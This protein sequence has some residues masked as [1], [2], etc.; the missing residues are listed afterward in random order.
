M[1]PYWSDWRHRLPFYIPKGIPVSIPSLEKNFKTKFDLVI[2]FDSSGQYHLIGKRRLSIPALMWSIDT[3]HY[4]KRAFQAYF[5][6]DFDIL[7]SSN[8]D[9]ANF[10][11]HTKFQWLP[12]ACDPD[13]HRKMNL[14]KIYDVAFV[15]SLDP[16]DYP[17]RVRIL[18]KLSKKFKVHTFHK[19]YR[20]EMVRILNQ[21]KIVFNKS[22][23]GDINFRIFETLSCG[24]FLITDRLNNG[25]QDLF[26]DGKHLAMYDNLGELEDKVSYY[27]T[28]DEEREQIASTGQ[29]EV[30][31]KHTFY[32][33]AKTMLDDAERLK[34]TYC[35]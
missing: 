12:C 23:S 25:L 22:H 31:D 2:E 6:K 11:K 30:R 10:F 3:H 34:Q 9:H 7:Y 29:K 15:G 8:M 13:F 4:D 26:Q 1:T 28:H 21:A 16:K 27:L 24:S 19:V 20:E 17:E 32:H 18:E 33:R 5:Q 35:R 14:P